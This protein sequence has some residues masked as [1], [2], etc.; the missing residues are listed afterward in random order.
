[1]SHSL[2][3]VKKGDYRGE[4]MKSALGQER[5]GEAPLTIERR[6]KKD[7]LKKILKISIV[8]AATA[9]MLL[10]LMLEAAFTI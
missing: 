7:A 10:F 8:A 6:L 9:L 1:M 4:L 3:L 2:L 5:V